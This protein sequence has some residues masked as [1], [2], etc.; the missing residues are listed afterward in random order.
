MHSSEVISD[1][2]IRLGKYKTS[3]GSCLYIN[4]LSDVDLNVL[5]KIIFLAYNDMKKRY[6]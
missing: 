4:K 3:K 1:L 5:E 2:L 6:S